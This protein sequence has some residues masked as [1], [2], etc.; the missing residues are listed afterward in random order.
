MKLIIITSPDFIPDEARIVTELF[1]AG[2][3]LLHVRKPDADVHAV[4]NLLQGIAVRC[5][6]ADRRW[7][8][9]AGNH[10]GCV[11]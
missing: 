3:D 1:K 7:D 11:Q 8:A 2:L 6:A 9:F 10:G 4:E 5:K